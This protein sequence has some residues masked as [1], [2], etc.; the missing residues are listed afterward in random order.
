[1]QPAAASAS[2]AVAD[3]DGMTRSLSAEADD[4]EDLGAVDGAVGEVTS[5][6]GITDYSRAASHEVL[7]RKV[8]LFK[9]HF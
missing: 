4:D 6:L 8:S 5:P 9:N 7:L 2:V 3:N 1:M